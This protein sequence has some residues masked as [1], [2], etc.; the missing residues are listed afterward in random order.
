MVFISGRLSLDLAHTGGPGP[1][2]VFERLHTPD[3]L[4]HWL[5]LSPLGIESLHLTNTDLKRAHQLRWAIYQAATSVRLGQE[6]E[7]SDLKIINSAAAWTPLVPQLGAENLQHEW[8]EPVTGKAALSTIA[9][10]AIDL[11]T[12]HATLPIQKCANPTCNLLFVDYSRAGKR[13]WCS[14]ERCGNLTKVAKY[15]KKH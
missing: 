15:R 4:A 8:Q 5:A 11:L 3:D 1:Y 10:D 9:R 12:N 13:K 6:P 2:K 14:M 7:V